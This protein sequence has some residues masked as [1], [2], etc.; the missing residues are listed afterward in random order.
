LIAHREI[1]MSRLKPLIHF[2]LIFSDK[3]KKQTHFLKKFQVSSIIT[4]L[5]ILGGCDGDSS[6]I[7]TDIEPVYDQDFEYNMDN[8][9]GGRRS[10]YN[11]TTV[12]GNFNNDGFDLILENIAEHNHVIV[13]FDLYIHDS[14]DGNAPDPDGPD[15]W[16]MI[17]NPVDYPE[18]DLLVFE[19]TFS[20]T[21]CDASLC[22][23]QAFPYNHPYNNT[24]RAGTVEF[25]PGFCQ[26]QDSPVGTSLYKIEKSFFHTGN[27]LI[28]RFEDALIQQNISSARCDESWSLDNL[29]IWIADYQ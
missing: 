3:M 25:L 14:W 1:F 16:R 21:G 8:I 28:I 26:Y 27:D 11:G 12:L 18:N 5:M 9:V 17:T 29:K 15:V 19:T 6:H 20:N 10:Q 24:P 4:F 13:A 23:Q 7:F 22:L 2:K